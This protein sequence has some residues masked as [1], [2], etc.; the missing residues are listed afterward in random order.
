MGTT[1]GTEISDT[2]LYDDVR[3]AMAEVSTTE[4]Q[5]TEETPS[6]RERGEDGKFKAKADEVEAA[7]KLEP[8]TEEKAPITEEPK[9]EPERLLTEDKAPRGWSPEAREKWGTIPED[10]R[11][12]ILRREEASAVGVRQLQEKYAPMEGF[13]GKLGDFLAEA[14]QNN[15]DPSVYI[16]SVLATERGLRT[17]GVPERFNVLLK[18]ADDYGIP[19]RDIINE[20]VG[21]K[22][23]GPAAP[24]TAATIPPEV[25]RELQ[26]MR[27]WRESQQQSTVTQEIERFSKDK[28]FFADVQQAMA[29]LLDA[30]TA[31]TLEEAYD[32]ACWANP[33][34]RNV[35]LSR[36]GV[37]QQQKV[38]EGAGVRPAG[39][40]PADNGFSDDDD[41][42]DTVRKA[43]SQGATGRV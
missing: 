31:N 15:V 24:Q 1:T 11:Q 23:L 22:V 43:F 4:E 39:A 12:E 42:A 40:L 18:I 9:K 33:S 28:E 8:K 25:Q 5:S 21:Q 30:G 17:G 14:Q 32:A 26:E 16:P 41:L 19:L 35:L 34:I 37:A 27:A 20:S 38:A 29:S 3:A 7:A 36:Q 6:S 13:V 2:D 10:L